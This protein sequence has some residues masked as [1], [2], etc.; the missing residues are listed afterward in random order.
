MALNYLSGR[1]S[2]F[3]VGVPGFSTAQDLT[4]AVSGAIGVETFRPRA[5][6]DTP[7]ISIRGAIYD[8]GIQTGGVGYFLSQDIEGVKWVAASPIDLTFVRVFDDDAY[9]GPSNFSGLNFKSVD[10]EFVKI[11]PNPTDP[12][13]ADIKYDVRWIRKDFGPNKGISTGFGTDGTFWSL[14]GYGTSEAAGITSVGIGTDQPQDDFQVGIGSTGVTINGELGK[15]EAEIIKAKNIQVEGN[16]EVE[17]LIVRPGFATLTDLDVVN[18]ATIPTEYVGFSSI[19]E[20][21]V[22]FIFAEQ[23]LAGLTTLG[24]GGQDVFVLE[25]LYVQGGLGTFTGDVFV[26]GDL[27]VAG[28]VFFRQI[29]AEN[30]IVTGISTLNQVEAAGIAA[31]DFSSTGFSTLTDYSFVS[32][33]GSSLVVDTIDAGIGTFG[34][35]KVGFATIGF[36]SITE[37]LSE[38]INVGFI[39]ATEIV[40]AGGTIGG[41]EVDGSLVTIEELLVTG[42]STFTGLGTFIGDLYVGED[43]FVRGDVTFRNINAEQLLISGIGTIRDLEA[44]TG[45]VTTFITENL[46]NIAGV[47]TLN[48]IRAIQIETN[49]LTAED[50]FAT[51]IDADT[52]RIGILTGDQLNY[53][54]GTITTFDSEVGFVS[55]LSGNTLNFSNFSFING[56]QFGDEL[57]LIG[58]DL[59]VTGITTFSGLGTFGNDLYVRN[60]LFV[61]GT[62]NFK[63]LSGENLLITGIATVNDVDINTGIATF[64]DF[65]YLKAG[66]ATIT[67]LDSEFIDSTVI[68][69]DRLVVSGLATIAQQLS[70]FIGVGTIFFSEADGGKLQT[71]SLNVTGIGTVN[72][73]NF[74]T[75]VGTF[76]KTVDQEI[77]GVAT[78]NELDVEEIDVEEAVVGNLKVT[79]ITTFDGVVNIDEVEFVELNV[80]GI[81]SINQLF[82]NVGVGTELKVDDLEVVGVATIGVATVGLV[83]AKAGEFTKLDV[84]ESNVEKETVGVLSVTDAFSVTGPS[85]FVG[86][87]TYTGDVF[88]KGDLTVTGVTTFAQL[89]AQQSQIGI[90]TVFNILESQE[91]TDLNQVSIGGSFVAT[92]ISTIGLTTF[93]PDGD[94]N[95]NRNL[96]VGGIVTFQNTVNIEQVEFVELNVTGISSI[97]QLFVNSGVATNFLIDNLDA[98]IGIV[99]SLSVTGASTFV[100]LASFQDAVFENLTVNELTT[101]NDSVQTGITSISDARIDRE[102]VGFSSVQQELVGISTIDFL[103]IKDS[104]TSSGVATFVGDVEIQSDLEVSG[105]TKL[106]RLEVVG[107]STLNLANIVTADID[108]LNASDAVIGTS[109]IGF[110]SITVLE[111]NDLKVVGPSTFTG[112]MFI[113]GDLFVTGVATY[114]QLNAEQSIIG[115]LTVTDYLDTNNLIITGITTFQ[116]EID[117]NADIEITA[118]IEMT[119]IITATSLDIIYGRVGIL[120]VGISSFVGF[121][122]FN[123]S[124][125]VKGNANINTAEIGIATVGFASVGIATIGVATINE[126]ETFDLTVTGLSTFSDDAYFAENVYIEDNLFVAGITTFAQLN[127]DQSIIGILTVTTFNPEN[128]LQN[129]TGFTTLSDFSANSGV[130][131]SLDVEEI[132]VERLVAGLATATDLEVTQNLLVAGITTLGAPGPTG[133]V[134][135]LGDLYVGGDLFVKD[136]IFKDEIRGRNAYITGVGTINTLYSN[137]GFITTLTVDNQLTANIGVITTLTVEESVTGIATVNDKLEVLGST[138]L[139]RLEVVGVSTLNLAKIITAEI[140]VLDAAEA[141]IGIASITNS[142]VSISTITDLDATVATIGIATIST[143]LDISD[144]SSQFASRLTSNSTALQEIYGTTDLDYLSYEITVQAVSGTDIHATKIHAAHDGTTAIFN[145]YSTIFNNTELGVYDVQLSGGRFSVNV[146]PSSAGIITYTTAITG[147]KG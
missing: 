87:T 91:I 46:Q 86:F 123:D 60:D 133:F 57:V 94:V 82:F 121:S 27:T 125:E 107:V 52:G 137:V 127:A 10:N 99:T 71:G 21:Q 85:S 28:E 109:R 117:I 55:S 105:A 33:I 114:G 145:E 79:G 144:V 31:T 39:S 23:V 106:D 101:L 80:T 8:A 67:S 110:S 66:I 104:V 112:D 12:E 98:N 119:G 124:I 120:T 75:G 42:L 9:V 134:T 108:V 44:N 53:G 20:A 4:L 43:L 17:S 93:T 14:P 92:G 102:E 113:D 76:L 1:V 95:I 51:D 128:I 129:P 74:I 142:N 64:I 115:I 63:Q 56:A 136:D 22:D 72:N 25:D 30:I 7:N 3:A 143:R 5:E 68:E 70:D 135:A 78:V 111:T 84:F 47:S 103:F 38:E 138:K 35:T 48:D 41:L 140:D 83:T 62:L 49:S 141:T 37:V 2:R 34:S 6:I 73:L 61:G 24:F 147:L 65:E 96:T 81:S 90:L 36:A 45:V 89:D 131:T 139:E 29:N 118:N 50:I 13:L 77:V 146:T 100:G 122:T 26:G 16:L 11:T 130:V 58:R 88:V 132:D 116:N 126:L 69:N 59:F 32:G 18:T 40:A 19:Q 54:L 97:N 15:V